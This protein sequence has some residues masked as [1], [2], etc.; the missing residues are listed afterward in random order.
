MTKVNLEVTDFYLRAENGLVLTICRN[1]IR[2]LGDFCDSFYKYL[3]LGLSRTLG[4]PESHRNKK[5]NQR[6]LLKAKY[7]CVLFIIKVISC[8]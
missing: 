4:K 8:P 3:C 2:E 6:N 7:K 1:K 5:V